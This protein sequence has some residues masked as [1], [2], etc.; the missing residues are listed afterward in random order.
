[1]FELIL[2][3]TGNV[4]LAIDPKSISHIK[5]M[6]ADAVDTETPHRMQT[7]V[8]EGKTMKVLN[9]C[10]SLDSEF[11]A[12]ISSEPNVIIVSGSPARALWA[13]R[14]NGVVTVDVDQMADLPAV[15]KGA[16][17]ACFSKVVRLAD[18]LALVVDVAGLFAIEHRAVTVASKP[19]VQ[20]QHA[21]VRC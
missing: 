10:D 14:V 1:M 2:F 8:H 11:D 3:E 15:Y 16:A 13:D 12:S 7:I 21:K 20:R 19:S 17:R 9:L 18:Q 5:S 6:V 4:K